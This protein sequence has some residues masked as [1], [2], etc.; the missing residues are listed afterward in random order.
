[1]GIDPTGYQSALAEIKPGQL[2][3]RQQRLSIG[4]ALVREGK[5]IRSAAAIAQV[6]KSTLHLYATG[7]VDILTTESSLERQVNAVHEASID[8]SLI[9]AEAVIESLSTQP[10]QWRPADLV[11]AYGVATDKVLAFGQRSKGPEQGMSELSK[12]LQGSKLTI[13]PAR[14][15]DDAIE[16]A[17]VLDS[18]VNTDPMG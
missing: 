2:S 15:G 18:D 5:S 3:E 4:V 7:Q 17:N 11:K 10:D 1:M 14:P 13:E 6:P 16:V 8:M 9:A 12:L